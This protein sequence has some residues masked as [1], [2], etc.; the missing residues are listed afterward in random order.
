MMVG[1][2]EFDIFSVLTIALT[3]ALLDK[4]EVPEGTN[5]LHCRLS[6]VWH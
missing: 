6:A 1:A 3:D 5:A 4:G 2:I